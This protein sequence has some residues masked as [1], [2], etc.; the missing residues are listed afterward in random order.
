MKIK[1]HPDKRYLMYENGEPF[2]YLG[3]TAWDMINLL[4]KEE[5]DR[6]FY[7]R[8]KQGFTVIQMLT[9]GDWYFP[10]GNAYGAYAI[11]KDENGKY[12][13]FTESETVAELMNMYQELTK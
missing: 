1:V 7:I 10:I 12:H 2:F 3:D 13:W 8:A 9:M 5:I 11:E 4:S 6:Y